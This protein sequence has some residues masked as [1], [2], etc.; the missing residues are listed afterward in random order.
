MNTKER[1]RRRNRRQT[2]RNKNVP[3]VNY[4]EA[5][6][7]NKYK[8][9][10]RLAIVVTVV[11]ALIFGLSIFFKVRTVEVAGVGKYTEHQIWEASGIQKGENLLSLSFAKI[12]AKIMTELPYVDSVRIGITL[13]GTVVIQVTELPV[14]YAAEATDGSWWLISA[15]G[16]AVEKITA[17]D[18]VGYTRLLGVQLDNPE[19]SKTVVAAEPE[20]E[21]VDGVTVPV[22]VYGRERLAALL[23]IAQSME[24]S[25]I[26]G[27]AASVDVSD[28]GAILLWYG[29]QYE[30]NFGEAVNL[31]YKV[32]A[33]KRVIDHP[34]TP[35]SG[36]LDASF[37]INSEAVVYKPFSATS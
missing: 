27:A 1:D 3:E 15:E 29:Q 18:A 28:M 23:T 4:T 20:P 16:K 30:V 26:F 22:T 35:D 5:K 13:P 10:L 25:G 9:L 34:D 19:A 24:T 7:F 32:E 11:L 12:S 8:L 31:A 37:T 6:P 14:V 2:E 21:I 36:H 17:S 33:M